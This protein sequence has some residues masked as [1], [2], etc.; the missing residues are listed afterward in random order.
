MDSSTPDM[1]DNKKEQKLR[2]G[3]TPRRSSPSLP[4]SSTQS[5]DKTTEEQLSSPTMG[6]ND[7]SND[8]HDNENANKDE[9]D[10]DK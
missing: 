10:N 7:N 2:S 6:D 3:R 9:N 1:D 8:D 4:R 5:D